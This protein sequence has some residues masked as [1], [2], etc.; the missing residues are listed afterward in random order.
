MHMLN[1]NLTVCEIAT[2]TKPQIVLQQNRK[3]KTGT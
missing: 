3:H 2:M 1:Q